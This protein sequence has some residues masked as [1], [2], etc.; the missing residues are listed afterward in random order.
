MNEETN[1]E[2][3]SGRSLFWPIVL[4]GVGVLWLL[5]SLGVLE[6]QQIWALARWWPLA[7][8]LI[9]VHIIIA[10]RWSAAGTALGI[11]MVALAVILAL[12]APQGAAAGPAWWQALSSEGG[13]LQRERLTEPV[14]EASEA[15]VSLALSRWRT[16][17]HALPA[18]APGTEG[19]LFDGDVSHTGTLAF[20]VSGT[21][22]KSIALS[23]R[24]PAGWFPL[25][26][27]PITATWDIG[28]NPRVP[29]TLDI[30]IGSGPLDADLSSLQLRDLAL[31]GGSGHA[32]VSLPATTVELPVRADVGSGAID[33]RS[34]A[35]SKLNA[36][37]R[38]GSG[39]LTIDIGPGST[40]TLAIDGGSGHVTL[41]LGA[42]SDADV[43]LDGGSGS[44]DVRVPADAG[45]RVEVASGGSGSLHLPGGMER[46]AGREGEDE[47][48]WES[49]GWGG[50]AHR[51][52]VEIDLGSG[53]VSIE[54]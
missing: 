15:H 22:L 32:I 2:P 27:G 4:I 1:Q 24:G 16:D 33:V 50:A 30:D 43:S 49:A 38:S 6:S 41:G 25:N 8:I 53:S 42:I 36:E 29:T 20:D 54:R 45:L 37:F 13:T 17:L 5:A 26:V 44:A 12:T 7:L 39:R 48:T 3:G 34:P 10:P 14:G 46:V 52:T 18:S 31:T 23:E 28:L 19:L 9:G 47:G 11:L 21:T 40:S 35:A 51:V